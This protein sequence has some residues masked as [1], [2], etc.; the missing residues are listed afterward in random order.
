MAKAKS[1]PNQALF[2]T[3]RKIIYASAF[4]IILASASVL[5]S[6]KS[7][8]YT[9]NYSTSTPEAYDFYIAGTET[10]TANTVPKYVQIAAKSPIR[11]L[12]PGAQL[13]G[14]HMNSG[15]FKNNHL[16]SYLTYLDGSKST[17]SF[18]SII[19]YKLKDSG[20][21]VEFETRQQIFNSSIGKC[22]LKKPANE[23]SGYTLSCKEKG[24][25]FSVTI[26]TANS[27]VKWPTKNSDS[28]K[29]TI[30]KPS[31]SPS[32]STSPSP[33]EPT[34]SPSPS[35]TPLVSPSPSPTNFEVSRVE[36][37]K[38][39]KW[40]IDKKLNDFG[41]PKGTNYTGGTPLFNEA[42]GKTITKYEYIVKK[43]TDKPWNK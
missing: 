14:M 42:T 1:K 5:L 7:G 33:S 21:T 10:S 15:S 3:R 32:P 40:I 17:I 19:N 30:P 29:S 6:N 41:D 27:I 20:N 23:S 16:P 37:A 9:L 2:W 4:A 36:R 11:P 8:A 38:I 26:N 13:M 34:S 39:D 28:K 22:S 35:P 24:K 12:I 43:Y 18:A 31:V 25:T